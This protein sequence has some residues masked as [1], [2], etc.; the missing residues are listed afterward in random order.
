MKYFEVWRYTAVVPQSGTGHTHNRGCWGYFV[1]FLLE[2]ANSNSNS[3]VNGIDGLMIFCSDDSYGFRRLRPE[4]IFLF[5][6]SYIVAWLYEVTSCDCDVM[7][8]WKCKLRFRVGAFC[9]TLFRESFQVLSHFFLFYLGLSNG[10]VYAVGDAV[11]AV[12]DGRDVAVV[13]LQSD[14]GLFGGVVRAVHK[15]ADTHPFGSV[16]IGVCRAV[17]VVGR[18]GLCC[19]VV[20]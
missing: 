18:A 14:L 9:I 19:V 6:L 11:V 7:C 10:A 20:S 3:N 1:F 17:F 5:C 4:H 15:P 12:L 13:L 2:K 8:F 16:G